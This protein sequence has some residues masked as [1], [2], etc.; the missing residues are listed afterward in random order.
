MS[1]LLEY[2]KQMSK[3]TE[4]PEVYHRALAYGML[5][6]LL[7]TYPNRC[8]LY[9]GPSR[10]WTNLWVM[11]VGDSGLSRKSTAVI[12]AMEVL[13][14]TQ[15]GPTLRAPDDGSPEGF[16]KDLVARER[17]S[18]MNAASMMMHSEMAAFLTNLTRDYMRSMK[19]MLMDFFD[20]P[21]VY[22]RALS[23]EEFSVHRPRFTLIGAAA[24]ELL[25]TM[26]TS[27][28]WLGGFMNRFLLIYARRTRTMEEAGTP[29]RQLYQSLAVQL[30]QTVATWVKTRKKAQA[31]LKADG[32]KDIFLFNYEPKARKKKQEL[33]NSFAPPADR[34]ANL[35]LGRQE[36]HL[37]KLCAIAQVSM[38]PTVPFISEAAVEEAS[39]LFTAYREA[40]PVLMQGSY[41]RSNTDIEG[42]RL[43]RTML[44][45]LR[46]AGETGVDEVDLME[47]TIMDHERFEKALMTLSVMG[48][49]QRQV[50]PETGKSRVFIME[51]K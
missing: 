46:D 41:A 22:R 9:G 1:F 7:T 10:R 19:G 29:S 6:A 48:L 26:T 47:G 32:K 17:A 25:P 13:N 8:V 39:S 42:D 44:R 37:M 31:K 20:A 11:L 21:P 12:M 2:E 34:N 38:D 30:D 5:G 35:L 40:A 3:Y 27:D 24:T 36:L 43:Q 4:A 45:I 49:A 18:K 15:D 28:D 23:K 51:R 14:E 16:A 50:E 33:L